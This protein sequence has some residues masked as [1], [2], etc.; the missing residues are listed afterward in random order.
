[1]S[2]LVLG[3]ATNKPVTVDDAAIIN[4]SFPGFTNLM[5]DLGAS[6]QS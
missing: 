2:F 6:F 3:L 4:T 5:A 1:M